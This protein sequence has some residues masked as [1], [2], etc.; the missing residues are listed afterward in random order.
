MSMIARDTG[1]VITWCPGCGNFGILTAFQRAVRE[2]GIPPWKI[3]VVTG[4]GC[5]GKIC[6]YIYANSLH[7]IHGRVPPI[8]TAIKLVNPEL[9][10]VGFA[11]DG[12][13]YGIGMGH[14]PHII[15]R[16]VDVKLIVH[17]N[18]LYGLTTGQASPTSDKG[19]KTRSTPYG[20]VEEPVNPIAMA[21]SL[22]ASFVARGFAGD[23]GH[24]A[25]LFKEAF[26]HKGFALID[27]FQP[28][29]T[30]DKIHTYQYYRQRVYK[31]EE[32]GHDP[33]NREEALRKAYECCDRIPIGIFYR[34]EKP[35]LEEQLPEIKDKPPMVD[36]PLGSSIRDLLAKYHSLAE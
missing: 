4:I 10:V 19:Q 15:R 3:V 16:N 27:V 22:G 26:K 9:L 20:V 35:T 29:I 33:S 25:W 17:N 5:H 28:C 6:N 36:R 18:R 2:L 13:A 7:T 34:V 21:I 31:L 23:P 1:Q 30:F 12:D 24:L 32:T 14:L 8:A 11:G